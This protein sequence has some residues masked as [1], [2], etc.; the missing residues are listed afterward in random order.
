MATIYARII[1]QY[2][3]K[4]H[5]IFSASFYKNNEEDQRSDEIEL[6]INFNINNNLTETDINN[7]DVKS[8]LEH[9]IQIQETKESGWIL[10]KLN[11]MKIGFYKTEEL[12]GSSYVKIPLRSNALLNIHNNDKFCFIWS[13][14]A[15][16][17]PCKNDH[18]N[19]VSIYIQYFNELNFQSFGFNCSDVHK[20]NDLINL[21]V[22]IFELNFYQDK[23]KWKHNLI[24]IEISKNNSDRVVDLLI[25]RNHYALIKKLNVFLGDHHKNFICRR[26]LNSYTSE[27]MLRIHK[28]KCENND[29]TT[30]RTS[31]ESHLHWENH[32]QKNP[33]YFRIYADFEA[34]NEKDN[35]IV[36]NKATNIYKQNPVLNGYR[37]VSKLEDVLQSGYYKSPL[38]YDNVDWFVDEVIKLENK[39]A[40]YFKKTKKDNIMKQKDEE[41]FGNINICRFCEKNIESDKVRDHCHLTGKYRGPAHSKCNINVTQ[42]Q[43][44]FIPFIFHNF[45]NYDCHLFFKRL[46][47]KKKDKVDFEIMPKTNEQY[48]SVT[49]G[50]IRFINSY[51]FLS[52]SLD[53]L[54]KTLVDNSHKTLKDFEEEIVDNDEILNNINKI[55]MLIEEDK[56]KNDSIKDLKKDYPDEN[57]ELEESLLDYMGENDLKI[58]KTEF[59]DKWKYLTKKLAYPYEFFNCIEDYQKPVNNLKKE[60]VFSKLKNKCPDD[61]EIER[62][63]EIIKIFDIKNGE[64]LT[65]IYLKSDV[66][67]LACVFEKFIKVS[68]GEFGINPLYCVNLPG[69]TWQY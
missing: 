54:V 9:Q 52:S 68:V 64:E 2:K 66:L 50:Y 69:Y 39:M 3:F 30:I 14:L 44:N 5:I 17:H 19:R 65:E 61:E 47:N 31:S 67:L 62:T 51:R 7:I 56:Y 46:V 48:I 15:S 12:N 8:Q 37:I 38:G 10:D 25:Y 16:L 28:P 21:S 42:K 53:S 26:C 27:N 4:F 18:P 60:H 36:G 13:I 58:L 20:F 33:L 29:I 59:P 45:S 49:Y 24:P 34:D 1:T 55:K 6:F 35:S 11:S 41:D 23:N 63:K 43:N 57:N 32:F 40:F 22:N